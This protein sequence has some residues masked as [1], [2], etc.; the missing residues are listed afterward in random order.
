MWTTM[1]NN[2][3]EKKLSCSFYLYSFRKYLSY[4]FPI[5]N[6]YNPGLHYETP[7][8]SHCTEMQWLF[9]ALR[10]EAVSNSS[11]RVSNAKTI[12]RQRTG[13]ETGERGSNLIWNVIAELVYNDKNMK[14]LSKWPITELKHPQWLE[15]WTDT[16]PSSCLR[17]R[18]FWQVYC[19]NIGRS[20]RHL[21]LS[22]AEYTTS[23]SKWICVDVTNYTFP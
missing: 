9:Y 4:G 6:F 19:T 7:C 18:I 15:G 22:V 2:L 23:S 11:Y 13:K 12:C 14:N 17:Q 3:L 16:L 21:I 8:I 5:I 10:N 20:V 1:K